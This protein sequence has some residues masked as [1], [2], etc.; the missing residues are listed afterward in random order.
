MGSNLLRFVALFGSLYFG[1]GLASPFFPIFLASRGVTPQQVGLALSLSAAVRLASGPLA[2]RLADYTH[3]VRGV[4]SVAALLAAVFALCFAIPSSFL[5][6]L[7]ISLLYAA[8]L[9]PTTSLGDALALRS[10]QATSTSPGFEY[11]WVRGSGSTVFVLGSLLSG[12]MMA[13]F[14][15]VSALI[16]QAVCL[17]LAAGAALKVPEIRIPPD[18]RPEKV[19]ALCLLGNRPFFLLVLSAA[20]IL[21][22]HAMHDSFAM[23]AWQAAQITP[24]M[25]SVLWSEQVVAE[26]LVFLYVGPR[27]LQALSPTSVIALA[28]VTAAIR[29]TV[30]GKTSSILALGCVEPLHGFTFALLHLACMR[31]LIVVSPAHLA[32]TAQTIYAFG[33]GACSAALTFFSGLLYGWLETRGFLVMAVLAASALPVAWQLRRAMAAAAFRQLPK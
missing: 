3:H 9:A 17:V 16:G 11:G 22:S 31:I 6:L 19:R 2:G 1:F 27:M 24:Q 13:M 25:A 5:V 30:V 15:P 23:I 12:Q 20:L 28:A 33:I 14:A 21:G 8:S 10:S 29:W 32:G 18:E 4:L 26:V 7:L